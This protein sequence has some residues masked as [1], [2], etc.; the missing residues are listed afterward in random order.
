MRPVSSRQAFCYSATI[1]LFPPVSIPTVPPRI[2]ISHSLR[3]GCSLC[4]SRRLKRHPRPKFVD[5]IGAYIIRGFQ[6]NNFRWIPNRRDSLGRETFASIN[7]KPVVTLYLRP[8]RHRRE[9]RSS[10]RYDYTRTGTVLPASPEKVAGFTGRQ[11]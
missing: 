4:Y 10:P 7:A 9:I 1:F 2:F 6:F 5:T 11:K 8:R 3:Q